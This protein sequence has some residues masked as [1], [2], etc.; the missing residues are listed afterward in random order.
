MGR[1]RDAEGHCCPAALG[2]WHGS[3]GCPRRFARLIRALTAIPP[4]PRLSS[5]ATARGG[6]SPLKFYEGNSLKGPFLCGNEIVLIQIYNVLAFQRWQAFKCW[7]HF[8]AP[9]QD[10][11]EQ[12]KQR[13]WKERVHHTQR[14][15]LQ[16]MEKWSKASR[17]E[18]IE[19]S[20]SG[21]KST[22]RVFVER[23]V[24]EI[25]LGLQQQQSQGDGGKK[26]FRTPACFS[27][28]FT[29]S[30]TLSHAG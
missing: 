8:S 6:S 12:A 27:R 7:P 21:G 4:F 19:A 30:V 2:W 10:R 13:S 23:M 26:Q 22:E 5:L 18:E 29:T 15:S 9:W 25:V 11:A 17:D 28:S 1:P 20:P 16:T 3:R 14:W 24:S